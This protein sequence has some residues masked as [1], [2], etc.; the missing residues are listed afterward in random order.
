MYN[1]SNNG[2][3]KVGPAVQYKACVLSLKTT[4]IF[5][6]L[7]RGGGGAGIG[8]VEPTHCHTEI[9]IF[10]AISRATDV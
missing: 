10:A 9:L 8:G 2:T 7:G 6:I 1:V 4:E 5:R 3:L